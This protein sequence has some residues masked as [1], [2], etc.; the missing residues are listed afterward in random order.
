MEVGGHSQSFSFQHYYNQI[1][2]AREKVDMSKAFSDL[3]YDAESLVYIPANF[4]SYVQGAVPVIRNVSG[5]TSG[6]NTQFEVLDPYQ[7]VA[8]KQIE[9]YFSQNTG[10]F[11]L[12]NSA[13][14]SS[15]VFQ[16]ALSELCPFFEENPYIFLGLG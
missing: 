1:D 2:Q 5:G 10:Q 12:N 13:T 7:V 8:R 16:V 15:T 11:I 6:V 14:Y 4:D 9:N 3:S